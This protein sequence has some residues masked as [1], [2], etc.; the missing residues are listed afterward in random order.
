M[1]SVPSHAQ[2][3][4]YAWQTAAG[5]GKHWP[6]AAHAELSGKPQISLVGQSPFAVHAVLP[7]PPSPE[8]EPLEVPEL[9]LEPVEPP[10]PPEPVE[11]PEL[12]EPS[13]VL[14]PSAAVAMNVSGTQ[15]ARP[16][17]PNN[18]SKSKW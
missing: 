15:A 6:V 8:P 4:L 18:E 17:R 16:P 5:A 11:P 14:P 12:L 13:P 3:A 10:E 9:E 1:I 7:V 2:P